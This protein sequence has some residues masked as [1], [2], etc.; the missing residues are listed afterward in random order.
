[1]KLSGFFSGI[2]ERKKRRNRTKMF[3]SAIKFNP[4]GQKYSDYLNYGKKFI[5]NFNPI[6]IKGKRSYIVDIGV[7]SYEAPLAIAV[8]S[9]SRKD[10]PRGPMGSKDF[11]IKI[12]FG[13]KTIHIKAIQGTRGRIKSIK[14]LEG[15]VGMPVPN[16]L[17]TII[18]E[19]AKRQGYKKVIMDLP[20]S[21]IYFKNPSLGTGILK[22]NEYYKE[23]ESIQKRMI[24]MYHS[25]ASSMGYKHVGER[26]EKSLVS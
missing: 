9:S 24:M 6:P 8:Y 4:E 2:R 1:M 13:P 26:F 16:Y 7:S 21:L 22:N 23:K 19:H 11:E 14:T 18:E 5:H 10:T 17:L 25:L 15:I 20:E 12:G 3:L